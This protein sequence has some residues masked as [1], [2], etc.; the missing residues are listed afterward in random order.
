MKK[1]LLLAGFMGLLASS[2]PAQAQADVIFGI[3]D[4]MMREGARQQQVNRDRE[5]RQQQINR[6]RQRQQQEIHR[7]QQA[8]VALVR[9]AQ[10]AL[11]TLGYYTLTVDGVAGPG[12]NGAIAAYQRAFELPVRSMDEHD[13]ATL[14]SRAQAGFRSLSEE[15]EAR[16][17]G[18]ASRSDWQAAG[19]AGFSNAREWE[20]ARSQGANNHSAWQAFNSSGFLS[21][22]E[23]EAAQARGFQTMR[24]LQSAEQAGFDRA[25][26]YEA[27]VQSGAADRE[28]YLQQ[29]RRLESAAA[30]RQE[31]IEATT[32][33]DW[34]RASPACEQAAGALRSDEELLAARATT[35]RQLSLS[36]TTVREKREQLQLR[37]DE[38]QGSLTVA[39][40]EF[41]ALGDAN[42]RELLAK[43][44]AERNVRASELDELVQE[45]AAADANLARAERGLHRAAC[46]RESNA[47]QWALALN[48]GRAAL[49]ADPN[50]QDSA[51]ML[52]T[53]EAEREA[54]ISRAEAER[55]A[56]ALSNARRDSMAILDTLDAFA[57]SSG[58][59]E[60]GLAISRAVVNLKAALE[61]EQAEIMLQAQGALAEL[62]D[63][64]ER[65]K[66]FR[67]AR[68]D[69]ERAAQ[70]S[71]LREAEG[72][73]KRLE[74]F[75][76]DH[77]ARNVLSPQAADLL[78][79]QASLEEA[80]ASDDPDRIVRAQ[81]VAM[82]E[83]DQL[84][85]G[86]AAREF[87]LSPRIAAGNLRDEDARAA[88]A[89]L[90]LATVRERSAL[91]LEE[92]ED[93]IETGGRFEAA[94]PVAR[95][96]ASFRIGLQGHDVAALE[97]AR[98]TL[99]DT[100]G[101]E[102]VFATFRRRRAEAEAVATSD[103]AV[104]AAAWL[105]RKR[106]FIED[107]IAGNPLD[108]NINSLLSAHAEISDALQAAIPGRLALTLDEIRMHFD[109]LG[110]AAAFE[111]HVGLSDFHGP[112]ADDVNR[113]PGGLAITALNAHLLDGEARDVLVL[114]N[115]S[116]SAPI[117]T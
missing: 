44:E 56:I 54:E 22:R 83:F 3:M 67:N 58:R 10:S 38:A 60:Q 69:A 41:D 15:R 84:G 53:V 20:E 96:I 103:G 109:E 85:L 113:A 98:Q 65:F 37:L 71:A 115:A 36:V 90:A 100:L 31:C 33:R 27:F 23:F 48:A 80:L 43:I 17:L 64:E 18:F 75:V 51:A 35:A 107:H 73:A 78:R 95:A 34:P 2:Q 86:E 32:A 49:E 24:A 45:L 21:F 40:A 76:R 26:E 25:E 93:F 114:R 88:E 102:E 72:N 62:L 1:Y 30:A 42:S 4:H 39:D 112:E 9:R 91:L 99:E 87:T 63:Q 70:A 16:A 57:A 116:G 110:L 77:L 28:T 12:T 55:H 104:T 19:A 81:T 13:I 59:F 61:Q 52:T 92:L 46:Y 89:R 50:D 11:K 106:I 8:Q 74:A 5:H 6:E 66:A 111:R 79:L 105:N 82:S 108:P 117:C 7:Q 97:E 14:E 68:K 47:Q 101:S 94:I 29:E